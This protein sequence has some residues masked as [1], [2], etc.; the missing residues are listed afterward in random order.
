MI[1]LI[2]E[3]PANERSIKDYEPRSRFS[4]Q[5]Y[6]RKFSLRGMNLEIKAGKT[7]GI[8]GETGCG[9]TLTATA[10]MGLLPSSAVQRGLIEF[11]EHG[12]LKSDEMASLRGSEITMIFKIHSRHLIQS[13]PWVLN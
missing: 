10:V 1:I 4:N 11:A 5:G 13:L 3:L 12:A 6:S 8:V 2:L 9:K 7:L